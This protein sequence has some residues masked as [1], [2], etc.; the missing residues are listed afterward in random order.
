MQ[1]I[2]SNAAQLSRHGALMSQ[3]VCRLR[4]SGPLYSHHEA[5]GDNPWCVPLRELLASPW[6]CDLTL[7]QRLGVVEPD[8]WSSLPKDLQDQLWHA[9]AVDPLPRVRAT[10]AKHSRCPVPILKIL[11]NDT[12][13]EIRRV[14][15]SHSDCPPDLL[16]RLAKDRSFM[17]QKEAFANRNCSL[18]TLQSAARKPKFAPTLAENPSCP[19]DVMLW[20]TRSTDLGVL[21]SLAGNPSSQMEVLLELSTESDRRIIALVASNPNCTRSLADSLISRLLDAGEYSPNPITSGHALAAAVPG[22]PRVTLANLATSS[23]EEIRSAVAYNRST[24]NDLLEILAADP[25]SLVREYIAQNPASST[26]ILVHLSK[27]AVP[28][29]RWMVLKQSS[30]PAKLRLALLEAASVDPDREQRSTVARY[31]D[32]PTVILSALANDD[33]E[34]VRRYV[35]L[36]P[37]TPIEILRK[38]QLDSS[39]MVRMQVRNFPRKEFDVELAMAVDPETDKKKLVEL[40]EYSYLTV[41]MAVLEN[42][43]T[44]QEERDRLKTMIAEQVQLALSPANPE[45]FEQQF[46][47]DDISTLIMALGLL[48]NPAD[49]KEVQRLAKSSDPLNRAAATFS[50]ALSKENLS[51]LLDD[52]DEDVRRIVVW[53]LKQIGE[54]Y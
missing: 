7:S 21:M 8:H 30:C 44:P 20:L 17:V 5:Y 52:S 15:A 14:V 18:E 33:D 37:R 41:R 10:L 39:Q 43:A 53:R 32:C 46:S 11:A 49:K 9:L 42:P 34:I 31:R 38:L 6:Q 35:A 4:A 47:I 24:S 25:S 27:D 23:K 16:A 26:D 50:P 29:V 19:P 12:E 2:S 36:N 45:H 3:L 40:A 28:R 1:A 22:C 13:P 48:R 51:R 54:S